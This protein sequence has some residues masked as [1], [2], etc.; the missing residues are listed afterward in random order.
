MRG[1]VIIRAGVEAAFIAVQTAF[2]G[3]VLAHDLG[4]GGLV[5][6]R[7]TERADVAATLYKGD[8][9]PLVAGLAALGIG[10]AASRLGAGIFDGAA[11]RSPALR[12]PVAPLRRKPAIKAF[13]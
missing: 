7:N 10:P 4:D 1:K 6:D 8:D 9:G 3:D 5:R 2:L 11:T 13:V 12:R